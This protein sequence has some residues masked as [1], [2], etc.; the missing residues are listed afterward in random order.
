M[1]HPFTDSDITFSRAVQAARMEGNKL[2]NWLDRDQVTLEAHA[3]RHGRS[4]RRFTLLDVV[5]LA[6]M[7]RIVEY[8]FTVEAADEVMVRHFDSGAST[9][10]SVVSGMPNLPPLGAMLVEFGTHTL[11]LCRDGRSAVT[12]G[13]P[14]QT[15]AIIASDGV[16]GQRPGGSPVSRRSAWIAK[17]FDT[18][19][20]FAVIRIGAIARDVCE[21]LGLAPNE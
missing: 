1:T 9:L 18:L 7:W 2:R 4:W 14:H 13:L 21:R 20:D 16:Q 11:I 17:E 5:R 19:T 12:A 8:G 15:L 3:E 10:R 6:I